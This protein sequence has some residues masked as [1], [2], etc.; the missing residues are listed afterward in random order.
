[1][2]KEFLA[3]CGLTLV[4]ILD[5]LFLARVTNPPCQCK[6][7]RAWHYEDTG[8]CLVCECRWFRK[9]KRGRKNLRLAA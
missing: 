1:M 7:G 5:L 9:R 6:H 8:K 2:L 3:T 4:M